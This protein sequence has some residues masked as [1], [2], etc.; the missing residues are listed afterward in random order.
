MTLEMI[1]LLAGVFYCLTMM[2]KLKFN[3]T[4][5]LFH[6][7]PYKSKWHKWLNPQYSWVNKYW[8]TD[9]KAPR[10]VR[11]ILTLLSKTV[12]VWLTDLWHFLKFVSIVLLSFLISI[13][14]YNQL[15][16][17]PIL[18]VLILYGFITEFTLKL[19]FH[20]KD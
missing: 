2:D 7:I 19:K 8:A 1:M 17:E 6:L 4:S 5:T 15:V 3:Y 18:F 11:I 13:L 10:W 16:F 12:F 20:N 14:L 9:I